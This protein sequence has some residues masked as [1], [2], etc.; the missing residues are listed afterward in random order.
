MVKFGIINLKD[1]F[2]LHFFLPEKFLNLVSNRDY[3]AMCSRLQKYVL[4]L[5]NWQ[6]QLLEED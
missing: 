3:H 5:V 2:R 1:A 4:G 6:S